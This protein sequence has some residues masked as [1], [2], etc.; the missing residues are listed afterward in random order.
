SCASACIASPR[1]RASCTARRTRSSRAPTPRPTRPRSPALAWSTSTTPP[2]CSPSRSRPSWP[3]S[4]AS[5]CNSGLLGRHQGRAVLGDHLVDHAVGHR[6][7]GTHD[8]VAVAVLGH[9]LQRLAGVLGQ[10]LLHAVAQPRHLARLDLDV[11][12]LTLGAPV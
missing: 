9:A 8:E 1:P 4:S 5:T 3:S 6:L 11:D 10:Q 12:L 2:T 7:L